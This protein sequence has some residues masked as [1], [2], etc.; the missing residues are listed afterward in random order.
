MASSDPIY[1]Y[2]KNKYYQL[3]EEEKQQIKD[4]YPPEIFKL[5]SQSGRNEKKIKEAT[6]YYLQNHRHLHQQYLK[7]IANL[8]FEPNGNYQKFTWDIMAEV[9]KLEMERKARGRIYGGNGEYS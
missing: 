2:K 9:D 7:E 8:I 6:D 3:Y 1:E 5:E 4:K